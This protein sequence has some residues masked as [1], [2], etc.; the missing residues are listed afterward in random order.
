MIATQLTTGLIALFL[1]AGPTP[2]PMVSA[3]EEPAAFRKVL[4]EG[5]AA[6]PRAA[7]IS[8]LREIDERFRGRSFSIMYGKY[9]AFAEETITPVLEAERTRMISIEELRTGLFK[10]TMEVEIES[11]VEERIDRLRERTQRGRG[12]TAAPGR[13]IPARERAREDAL[14]EAILAAVAEQYPGDSAPPRLVGRAYFLGTIR[15]EIEA[16]R[17]VILARIKVSL[18]RP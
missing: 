12:G 1:A 18:R 10:A 3:E 2:E 14:E 9:L 11:E 6:S 4:V 17:Y 7:P 16:G 13:L 5:V 15:E 8:A